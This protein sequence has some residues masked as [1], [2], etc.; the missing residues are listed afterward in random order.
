MGLNK[1]IMGHLGE[2]FVNRSLLVVSLT[3]TALLVSA[4]F[5]NAAI[6]SSKKTKSVPPV[7]SQMMK[8]RAYFIESDNNLLE[9]LDLKAKTLTFSKQH[10]DQCGLNM[11]RRAQTLT[12]SC[13]LPIPSNAKISR[14]QNLVTPQRLESAFGGSKKQVSTQVSSEA[15]QITFSTTFDTAGIDFEVSKFND[16]F[17]NVYAKAAQLIIADVMIKQPVRLEVLESR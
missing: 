2:S 11:V 7:Q 6:P 10:T 14:L 9:A 12:Y 15:R 1:S 17:Y 4:S 5:A 3:V 13:T 16:D 8:P